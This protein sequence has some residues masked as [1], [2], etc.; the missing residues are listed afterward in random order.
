MLNKRILNSILNVKYTVIDDVKTFDND[1]CIV[2]YVHPTKGQQC[3]CGICGRK[4]PYYDAGRGLRLWRTTDIGLRKVEICADSYRVKC[5]EHGVVTAYVPWARHESRHTHEFERT[6]AWLAMHCSKTAVSQFMRISWNTVGPMIS[7]VRDELDLDPESRFANLEKIGI[8]ET[9]YRKGHKYMTVVVNHDTGN[10][11][12]VAPGY[13][14]EVLTQFFQLLTEEQRAAI[15]VVSADGAKWIASCVETFCPNAVRCID[16]FHVVEWVNEAL[17]QV[18]I[19]SW[20]DAKKKAAP[21]PKRKPGRPAKGTPPKDN[22]AVVIKGS[23]YA[24]GKNPE[25]LTTNQ[26]A[27]LELIAKT[28]NRLWRAYRLKEE[29]RT[30]FQLDRDAGKEQLDHWVKWAQHCRIPSFVELQRKVRRHYDAILSTLES[31]I[32]NARVEAVNNKI[33]LSVRM[34]YGFRNI[35]NMIDMIMLRCSDLTVPLPWGW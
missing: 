12:W 31:G 29:I 26:Q 20:H 1:E 19:D 3:R 35:R 18:R 25:H 13:G 8:D 7:R 34:A 10:V 16:P 2:F 6:V 15:K 28:D 22:T 30:V 21:A 9:S 24:L 11:V 5:R 33:K 23:K 32:S 17:S 27:K 14:K 4:S